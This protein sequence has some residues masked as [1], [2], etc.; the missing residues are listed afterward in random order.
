ML[1]YYILGGNSSKY[2]LDHNELLSMVAEAGGAD[3][4]VLQQLQRLHTLHQKEDT[5]SQHGCGTVSAYGTRAAGMSNARSES[6]RIPVSNSSSRV[7]ARTS[8][9]KEA[10]AHVLTSDS[11]LK[12]RHSSSSDSK[13]Q[14]GSGSA[15][16]VGVGGGVGVVCPL[17]MQ[18]ANADIDRM[19]KHRSPRMVR[20]GRATL[21]TALH[22][23]LEKRELREEVVGDVPRNGFRS[24]NGGTYVHDDSN[25]N[26]SS[27]STGSR[28]DTN[29]QKRLSNTDPG[30]DSSS[31]SRRNSITTN[32]SDRG[33]RGHIEKSQLME[34]TSLGKRGR[35]YSEVWNEEDYIYKSKQNDVFSTISDWSSLVSAYSDTHDGAYRDWSV[36][37]TAL[38]LNGMKKVLRQRDCVGYPGFEFISPPVPVG[39]IHPACWG[40]RKES[41]ADVESGLD[42]NAHSQ[43]HPAS[44]RSESKLIDSPGSA[45]VKYGLDDIDDLSM[46]AETMVRELHAVEAGNYLRLYSLNGYVTSSSLIDSVRAKR[47]LLESVLTEMY[48]CSE[49]ENLT[50]GQMAYVHHLAKALPNCPLVDVMQNCDDDKMAICDPDD[51]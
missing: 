11:S 33:V 17:S 24:H 18:R 35:K 7:T 39:Q 5:N 47:L 25:N 36:H 2:W 48:K 12:N 31:R 1:V 26:N 16:G 14:S 15:V 21:C 37:Q 32:N 6:A 30:S 38:M 8:P 42:R 41:S 45:A 13:E 28:N 34:E 51:R 9:S 50:S 29:S 44:I 4:G 23:Q 20:D 19:L 10:E 40:L 49:F 22:K 27:S 43:M 3:E 46:H